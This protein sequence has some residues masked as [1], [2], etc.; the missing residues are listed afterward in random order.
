MGLIGCAAGGASGAALNGGSG[1]EAR[2]CRMRLILN[3]RRVLDILSIVIQITRILV[4]KIM[5]HLQ[6]CNKITYNN[7][8][9][10]AI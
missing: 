2:P 10:I 9:K 6:E 8:Q 3:T 5:M 1:W 7:G 4:M